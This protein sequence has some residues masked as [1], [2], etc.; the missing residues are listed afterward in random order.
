M[1]PKTISASAFL[2]ISK[3]HIHAFNLESFSQDGLGNV[4]ARFPALAT[5][6]DIRWAMVAFTIKESIPHNQHIPLDTLLSNTLLHILKYGNND[7]QKHVSIL[8]GT[9]I[10][11]QMKR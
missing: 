7:N 11:V 9:G 5:Q 1:C 8:Y 4:V 3:P 10:T 6:Q 2:P